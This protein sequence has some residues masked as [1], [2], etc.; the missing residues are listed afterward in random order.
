MGKYTLGKYTLEK[1][2]L[3]KYT[4]RKYT[5]G[6]YTFGLSTT[7]TTAPQKCS[8]AQNYDGLTDGPTYGLIWEGARDTCV[9]KNEY[10]PPLH[11]P[12]ELG[13]VVMPKI[14]KTVQGPRKASLCSSL[15]T[16]PSCCQPL[17]R[18]E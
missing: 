17:L 10:W 16:P 15:M 8:A 12:K 9:S 7:K 6:K 3:E 11:R 18:H 5:I 13:I 14:L 1:H 4:F 2:A